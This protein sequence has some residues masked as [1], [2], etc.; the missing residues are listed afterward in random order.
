MDQEQELL[1]RIAN[2]SDDALRSGIDRVAL[3]MGVSPA[4][5]AGYLS[6]LDAVRRAAASLT[7]ESM[8]QIRKSLG[9]ETVEKLKVSIRE[10]LE[11]P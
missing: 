1:S 8:E 10:S 7:P 5:A 9:E 4:L 3:A 2:L 6:D 11:N